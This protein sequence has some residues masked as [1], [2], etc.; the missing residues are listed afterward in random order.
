[1]WQGHACEVQLVWD[2]WA[3][4]LLITVMKEGT[5]E[6]WQRRQGQMGWGRR[7]WVW[8]KQSDAEGNEPTP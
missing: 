5:Y 1:M 4:W 6:R 8:G 7:R 3:Q 2:S